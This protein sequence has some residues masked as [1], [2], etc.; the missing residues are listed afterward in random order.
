MKE[1]SPVASFESTLKS[2]DTEELIDIYFYRP[3]GYAWALFFRKIGITPNQVTITAI[4]L[5][6]TAGVCFYFTH[7]WVNLL[8]IFLLIWANS[9]D[10]ADGQLARMSGQTSALGRMLDGLCGDLWFVTIYYALAFRSLPEWGHW[11]WLLAYP[12]GYFHTRQAAMA[13]YYRNIHLLFLKG[14]SGSELD[15]SNDL[16]IRYDKLSWRKEPFSKF[17]EKFYLMYTQGQE[18]WSP[19]LQQ[20]LGILKNK[21][22]DKAPEW[23]QTEFRTKSLPLMKYTNWLSFNVRSIVL[24]TAV[25]TNKP[26]IF[27]LLDWT[28]LNIMLVYMIWKHER[29]CKGFIERL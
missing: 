24:F 1:N 19:Q 17:F 9:Y 2:R 8:G 29:I 12:A 15:R 13:D 21:Y 11:I 23:F 22:D 25:L 7:L 14:K 4:F 20:M 5:G 28:V 6:I 3:V 16:K 26:W 10:S 27:Y 18:K